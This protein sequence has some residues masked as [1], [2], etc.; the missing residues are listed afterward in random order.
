MFISMPSLI[1]LWVWFCAY[2]NCV[3]W[4]LSCLH[5]L[6]AG[7][8]LVALALGLVI[9]VV[10][11][12]KSGNPIQPRIHWPKL[13]RRFRR[14]FPAAFLVLA[15]LAFL[16]G[17]LHAPANY[18]ALAYRTPRVLHWLA[19]GQW[20]WI[21][22]EFQRLNTRTAGFEWLTAPIFL[23]T[24]TDRLVFLLN[25]IS[26]VL[27]PGRF[28]ALLTQLGVRPRAAWHWMWLFPSG[29]GYALQAGSVVNDMFGALLALTALEF[30]L[31]AS[32]KKQPSDLW[33]ALL[34]AA[35]MTAAKAFNLLLLLPWLL[36]ALP[37][38]KLLLRRPVVSFAVILFAASASLFPTA[39]LNWQQCRDWTGL[40]AEQETIGGGGQP[41]RFLANAITLPLDNLV[42]PI[43]PWTSQW[44][45]LMTRVVPPKLAAKL[46]ASGM[47][48]GLADFHLGEMQM[49]ESAGLGLGLT[50][51]LLALLTRKIRAGEIWPRPFF[52]LAMLI[53]LAAWGCLGV[54]MLQVG[55][56][57]PARYLLPFYPL[58]VVPIL[59]GRA[60]AGVFQSRL[61][62]GAA[63]AVFGSTAM[64]LLVSP[65]RPLWPAA[66][67]LRALGAEHSSHRLVQRAEVVYAVYG[68]RANG[69]TPVIAALP[70]DANPLGFLAF[71]EPEAG[72]WRPFGTRRIV[73]FCHDDSPADLR[74]RGLKYALVSEQTLLTWC[75]ISPADWLAHV[76]A[77]VVE[78]FE[79]KL[80]AGEEPHG[81]LLVRLR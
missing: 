81:W 74:A 9:L 32:R 49:E 2:L 38:L 35:L 6:N 34:A 57:G 41:F 56:A 23:F 66:T 40:K 43:F 33:T 72:L 48:N 51:L 26:F 21:H 22:T 50:L 55:A 29:Y 7:G 53:P 20:H 76:Q 15:T 4:I 61:W 30:A 60:A 64:L 11:Q 17:T 68:M 78:R 27:L 75:H 42:P 47:E 8:Y 44:N 79:L 14:G 19:A 70:A 3:G 80:R 24:G 1:V 25:V 62:R 5:Q 10:W 69:F 12:R 37:A 59:A 39:I 28:F 45:H 46:R 65:P 77:E 67:V 63:W 18:D 73:H 36:A 58:L 13:R 52:T 54:F 16:G 71:D 31:R